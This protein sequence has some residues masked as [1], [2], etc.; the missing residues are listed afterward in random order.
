MEET[1][2]LDRL[3]S[4]HADGSRKKIQPADVKGRWTTRRHIVFAILIAIY[5]LAAAF[6]LVSTIPT[7]SGKLLGERISRDYVLPIFVVAAAL[8]ALLLTFPYGTLTVLTLLY[9][10]VIPLSYRRFEHHL[11]KPTAALQPQAQPPS[12][13][14]DRPDDGPSAGQT[15]H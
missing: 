14:T 11:S 4:I 2:T 6:L 5:V 10:A 8:V 13:R 3:S 7:F 1:P 15:R 12:V 9:L